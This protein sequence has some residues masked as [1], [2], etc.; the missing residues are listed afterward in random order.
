MKIA[1]EFE[2]PKKVAVSIFGEK[3]KNSTFSLTACT[4]GIELKLDMAGFFYMLF[5]IPLLNFHFS[6][7]DSR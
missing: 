2:K 5:K 7:I 1:S 3:T 6:T 4:T